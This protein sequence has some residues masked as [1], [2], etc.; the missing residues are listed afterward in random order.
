MLS[1]RDASN[2][3]VKGELKKTLAGSVAMIFI[4][5]AIFALSYLMIISNIILAAAVLILV[6]IFVVF[7]SRKF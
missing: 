4:M 1:W 5:G 2:K 6:L 3:I 7:T